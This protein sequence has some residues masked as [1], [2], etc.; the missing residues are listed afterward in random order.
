MSGAFSLSFIHLGMIFLFRLLCGREKAA[1]PL[2]VGVL[3]FSNSV[4]N[5][6]ECGYGISVIRTVSMDIGLVRMYLLV[7]SV[8]VSTVIKESSASL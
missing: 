7:V 3:R 4:N 5:F 8:N 2:A 1:V 6:I